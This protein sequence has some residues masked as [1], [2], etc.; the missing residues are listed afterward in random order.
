M[1]R[2][3]DTADGG[4]KQP[5]EF[6]LPLNYLV[7]GVAASIVWYWM[8]AN[9]G[10]GGGGRIHEISFQEFKSKLLAQVGG[11]A[12][13]CVCVCACVRVCVV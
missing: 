2:G 4:D 5:L 6:N 7:L 8:S 10:P 13:V 11:M 1:A 3:A 9:G 12:S